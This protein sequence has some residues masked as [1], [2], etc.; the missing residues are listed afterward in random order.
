[1]Y[2]GVTPT[3]NPYLTYQLLNRVCTPYP[4]ALTKELGDK[5]QPVVRFIIDAIGASVFCFAKVFKDKLYGIEAGISGDNFIGVPL[6]K[7]APADLERMTLIAAHPRSYSPK[8]AGIEE[9]HGRT[10]T[11]RRRKKGSWTAVRS[12]T[13]F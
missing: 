7:G 6:C 3:S 13:K 10:K 9:V 1:V 8:D 11:G 4:A 2:V 12:V 5:P